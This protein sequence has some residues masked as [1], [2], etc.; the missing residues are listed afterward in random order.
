MKII[1]QN[2]VYETTTMQRILLFVFAV[3]TFAAC[4][5]IDGCPLYG[6]RP[7]GSFS[8]QQR[9]S[10]SNASVHWISK[11]FIG[12]VPNALGCVGNS[13][14]LVCQSNGPAGDDT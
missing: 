3:F 1:L 12:P 7:S 2:K 13:V 10:R 5:D 6:C 11:G 4:Q 9:I 8:F 14:L